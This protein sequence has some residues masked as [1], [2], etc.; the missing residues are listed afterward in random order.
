MYEFGDLDQDLKAKEELLAELKEVY[1][2]LDPKQASDFQRRWKRIGYWESAYEDTLNEQFEQCIDACYATQREMY[3]SNQSLK[4]EVIAKAE[5]LLASKDLSSATKAMNDLMAEWKTIKSAGR[6]TDDALWERFNGIRQAL[7]DLKQKNWQEL[8]DKFENAK[9]VKEEIIVKAQ[10]LATSVEWKK[11]SDA[12]AELLNQ[13]KKVGSAGKQH[14]DQLWEAFNQHRQTFYEA[15]GVFYAAQEVKNNENYE[16]KKAIVEQARAVADENFYSRENTEKMK[17]FNV[18]WKAV[19]FSG[20]QKDDAIWAEFRSVVDGYFAGLKAYNEERQSQ[21]HQ[22]MQDQRARKIEKI[23]QEKRR[24]E[25]LKN[26]LI[27]TISERAMQDIQDEIEDTK[28][29]IVELEEELNELN[30]SLAK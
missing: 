10:A 23:D 13:W 3:Q 7:F 18:A 21:W 16:A 26:D 17:Q 20:R 15:R 25:R 2:T 22:R 5:A 4:E 27:G 12:F 30:K 24:I 9:T 28:A 6:N 19:G 14:E 11:T 8:Q 29:F 1:Q